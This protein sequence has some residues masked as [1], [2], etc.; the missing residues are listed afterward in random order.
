VIRTSVSAQQLGA[1]EAV[2]PTRAWRR[3]SGAF[4]SLK[5]VDL[6]VRPVFHYSAPRV[7]AHVFLC[8]LA[9]YV[10]CTCASG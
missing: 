7:R 5:T 8:L 3:S 6:Q 4:R 1:A 10:E 9:Y 2:A